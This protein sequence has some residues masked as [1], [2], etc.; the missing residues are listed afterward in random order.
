MVSGCRYYVANNSG[1]TCM[2]LDYDAAKKVEGVARPAGNSGKPTL[3]EWDGATCKGTYNPFPCYPTGYGRVLSDFNERDLFAL[4]EGEELE[5]HLQKYEDKKDK[6]SSTGFCHNDG[7]LLHGQISTHNECFDPNKQ[8][9]SYGEEQQTSVIDNDFMPWAVPSMEAS[10]LAKN[11]GIWTVDKFL[12]G[13]ETDKLSDLVNKYGYDYQLFGPCHARHPSNAH[14][15]EEKVCFKISPENVCEGPYDIS[16]CSTQTEKE[17]S[18]FVQSILNKFKDLWSTNVE[19]LTYIKFQVSLGS[20]PPVDLHEDNDKSITFVLYLNDGGAAMMFPNA[21]V[22]VRPGKGDVYTWLN[23]Y[24]D[25][26]V[27]RMADHAVQAQPKEAGERGVML[28][29]FEVS[30]DEIIAAAK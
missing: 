17:D 16:E 7:S 28:L 6:K 22:T 24:A 9:P 19:P 1:N 4:M 23:T 3:M 26:T 27:N 20:T 30:P 2:C 21:N 15:I 29:S 18:E 25:G 12:S 10:L 14:P 8:D 13:D 5:H 11:P